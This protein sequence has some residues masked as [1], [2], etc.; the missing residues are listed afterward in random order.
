MENTS[1]RRSPMVTGTDNPVTLPVLMVPILTRPVKFG[2]KL[3]RVL[4]IGLKT[5]P[6]ELYS[7]AFIVTVLL[8]R[9]I[10]AVVL[11]NAVTAVSV[12]VR[13]TD[14]A[15]LLSVPAGFVKSMVA[16]KTVRP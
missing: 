6:V 11:K 7:C 12:P 10:E 8:I 5:F 16:P 14:S 13:G 4:A 1:N 3:I 9:F 15:K 2:V